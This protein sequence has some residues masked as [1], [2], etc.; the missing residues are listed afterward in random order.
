M[1]NKKVGLQQ[2][3][4]TYNATRPL[5]LQRPMCDCSGCDGCKDWKVKYGIKPCIK[6]IADKNKNIIVE[7]KE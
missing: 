6:L 3:N 5:R 7:N 2:T 1:T 4:Y